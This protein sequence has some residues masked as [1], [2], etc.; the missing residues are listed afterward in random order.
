MVHAQGALVELQLGGVGASQATVDPHG[1][2]LRLTE[3]DVGVNRDRFPDL[4]VPGLWGRHRLEDLDLPWPRA[5]AGIGARQPVEADLVDGVAL[6]AV[7]GDEKQAQLAR[8]L[9]GRRLELDRH[10]PRREATSDEEG[11]VGLHEEASLD[12]GLTTHHGGADLMDGLPAGPIPHEVAVEVHLVRRDAEGAALLV[13]EARAQA[14]RRA[15]DLHAEAARH[16][17]GSV[18]RGDLDLQRITQG[19]AAEVEEEELLGAVGRAVGLDHQAL[20]IGGVGPASGGQE[21]EGAVVQDLGPAPAHACAVGEGVAGV[22]EAVD[23]DV[24]IRE[25]Q[26]HVLGVR[27]ELDVDVLERPCIDA[28]V[29]EDARERLRHVPVGAGPCPQPHPRGGDGRKRHRPPIERLA[30]DIERPVDAVVREHEVVPRAVVVHRAPDARLLRDLVVVAGVW[31][32]VVVEPEDEAGARVTAEADQRRRE[33]GAGGAL[34]EQRD[35]DRRGV[36]EP[37]PIRPQIDVAPAAVEAQAVGHLEVVCVPE[38]LIP[39]EGADTRR[40]AARAR[41]PVEGRRVGVTDDG[42]LPLVEAPPRRRRGSRFDATAAGAR[43]GLRRV[44]RAVIAGITRA[45]PVGVRLRRVHGLRAVVRRVVH[46]VLVEV[47]ARRRRVSE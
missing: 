14:Q 32:A 19:R 40:E 35:G 39:L 8:G 6:G 44:V 30:I 3:G 21:L 28:H 27:E 26:P 29:R 18:G 42:A 31:I 11:L 45:V 16:G 9:E 24:G 47:V 10:G 5:F 17:V 43:G 38:V 37:R 41:G 7:A 23:I 4:A 1:W 2:K 15:P 25:I 12:A 13:G 22:G 33:V 20:T 46:A 36:V 34:E